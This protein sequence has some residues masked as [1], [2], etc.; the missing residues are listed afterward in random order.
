MAPT[1]TVFSPEQKQTVECGSAVKHWLAI[2][3]LW[4]QF[5]R[6]SGVVVFS[7]THLTGTFLLTVET[8]CASSADN[9]EAGLNAALPN[10]Y[11]KRREGI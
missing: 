1:R 2:V 8:R 3:R 5:S 6:G 4:V 11:L 9:S 10:V 7:A